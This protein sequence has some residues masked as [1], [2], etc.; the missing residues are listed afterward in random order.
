[1]TTHLQLK[2]MKKMIKVKEGGESVLI[3]TQCALLK[4][5]QEVPTLFV[6]WLGLIIIPIASQW[7]NYKCKTP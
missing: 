5:I 6:N 4:H 7:L 2:L 3:Y 1:M